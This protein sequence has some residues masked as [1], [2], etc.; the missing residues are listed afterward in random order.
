MMKR[1]FID[2]D[3]RE[4]NEKDFQKRKDNVIAKMM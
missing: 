3:K 1:G 4:I 2:W